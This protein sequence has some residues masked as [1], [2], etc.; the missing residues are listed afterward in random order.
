LLKCSDNKQYIEAQETGNS[1]A[2]ISDERLFFRF[3]H[4]AYNEFLE[5]K[6]D[7]TDLE[8]ELARLYHDRNQP[9]IE[10]L[11]FFEQQNEQMRQEIEALQAQEREK[12]E[13][14]KR[15]QDMCSDLDKFR[16]HIAN[17]EKHKQDITTRLEERKAELQALGMSL[18]SSYACQSLTHWI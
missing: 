6:D 17:L 12:A 2:M 15:K 8:D 16:N 3:L 13:F 10:E 18:S 14:E 5:G 1:I 11:A 7:F 9:V 4:R